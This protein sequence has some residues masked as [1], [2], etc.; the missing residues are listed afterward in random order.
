[1]R[2]KGARFVGRLGMD[3]K[4]VDEKVFRVTKNP[5]REYSAYSYQA[6]YRG[7]A[8]ENRLGTYR[9]GNTGYFVRTG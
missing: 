9:Q 5:D 2:R 6:L 4:V 7:L 3:G 8:P 1:M